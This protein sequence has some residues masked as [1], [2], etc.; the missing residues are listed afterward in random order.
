MYVWFDES[1]K[2]HKKFTARTELFLSA[3]GKG[4]QKN[5]ETVKRE[6]DIRHFRL[7]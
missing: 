3:G 5:T 4:Q 2:V 1:V 7:N 6:Q